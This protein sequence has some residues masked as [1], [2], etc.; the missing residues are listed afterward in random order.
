MFVLLFKCTSFEVLRLTYLV[1]LTSFDLRHLT[2][3][4]WRTSFEVQWPPVNWIMDNWISRL[5]ESVLPGPNQTSINNL[6]IHRLKESKSPYLHHVWNIL[7]HKWWKMSQN[8][9]LWDEFWN[10]KLK[11]LIIR[12][13]CQ[14]KTLLEELLC[15]VVMILQT[16]KFEAPPLPLFSKKV[17]S[18][19]WIIRLMLSLSVWPE[20]IQLSGGHCTSFDIPRL[21]Y[22][23]LLVVNSLSNDITNSQITRFASL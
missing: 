19:Y 20:V 6:E 14:N 3:L 9:H 5:I 8:W 1:R 18:V 13:T 16:S 21:T 11:K 4:I 15:K 2:Y 23:E 12:L 17:T 7:L 10:I 22:L